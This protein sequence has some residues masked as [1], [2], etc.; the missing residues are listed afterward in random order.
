VH[1]LNALIVRSPDRRLVAGC[2]PGAHWQVQTNLQILVNIIDFGMNLETANAAA[3]MLLGNGVDVVDTVNSSAHAES[4]IPLTVL[5]ELRGRGH[6]IGHIGPWDAAGAMELVARDA[7]TG[8]F[9]ASSD[10]R[11]Q[12]TAVGTT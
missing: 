1:T 6:V 4:R 12:E 5:E 2:T 10:P 8:L 7:A 3:R 9:D 11:R